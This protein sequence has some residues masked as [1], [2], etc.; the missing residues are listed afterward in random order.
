M[1]HTQGIVLKKNFYR[2]FDEVFTVYTEDFG[3]IEILGRGVKRSTAKLASHLQIF[4]LSEMEFVLGKKFR[5]LTGANLVSN[6]F[7]EN[8][9]V[10]IR[11]MANFADFIDE[12]VVFE[13][14]DG[15][16]WNLISEFKGFV[17]ENDDLDKDKAVIF[18]NF[19]KYRLSA[20]CGFE[21]IVNGCAMCSKRLP[22]EKTIFSLKDGGVICRECGLSEQKVKTAGIFFILPST[23]KLLRIFSGQDKELLFKIKASKDEIEDLVRMMDYFVK[24][25]IV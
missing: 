3:K 21:P 22:E 11:V 20:I 15:D 1:F 9:N 17:A 4:D 23:V 10:G 5:V 8:A 2:E 24:W 16:I 6:L 18:C 7:S 12:V 13:E 25:N 14:P 19:F